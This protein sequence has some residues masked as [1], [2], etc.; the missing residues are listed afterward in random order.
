MGSAGSAG[1][2][3]DRDVRG[4]AEQAQHNRN[5]PEQSVSA[6]EQL[7]CPGV[8]GGRAIDKIVQVPKPK[9][10]QGKDWSIQVEMGLAGSTKKK[11][12]YSQLLVRTLTNHC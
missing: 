5:G 4:G 6:R 1:D 11:Q 12:K 3:A 10:Q 7:L 9:G 2:T 8:E